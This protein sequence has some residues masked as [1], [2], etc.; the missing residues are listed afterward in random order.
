MHNRIIKF[1]EENNVISPHQSGFR[2]NHSTKDHIL[3]LTND[4]INRFNNHEYTGAVMFDLEKAFDKVWH[5]G[6]IYKL[7]SI[8]TPNMIFKWIVNFLTRR[9]FYVHY[10]DCISQQHN[11]KAGVPQG[12]IISP[13]LF[14]IYI[15]DISKKLTKSHG[16]FADDISLWRSDRKIKNLELYR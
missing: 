4:I 16:L 11:I 6:L 9:S 12:C 8:K 15:S 10:N 14:S 2:N 1:L 7:H 3:K 13:I 5:Q